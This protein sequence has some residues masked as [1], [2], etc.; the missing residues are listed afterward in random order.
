MKTTLAARRVKSR[1]FF[2][3]AAIILVT[4]LAQCALRGFGSAEVRQMVLV[5][6]SWV[7]SFVL[8]GV[9]V[10]SGHMTPGTPGPMSGLACLVS[11]TQLTLLTGGVESPYLVTLVSV[12]L[13][14]SMFTPDLWLPTLVSLVAMLGALLVINL[15]E[16]LPPRTFLPQML[17]YGGIG[18]IGFYAGRSY[19]KLRR[20]E[21]LAQEER[22]QALE[23]LAESERLRRH[24]ENERADMERLMMVG[25]L[26]AGV[27]HE[28][29]N[30]LAFVKSNLHYLQRALTSTDR[31][32]DVAELH[33][34]LDETHQGV[35]RIQRI[36][37]DL[38]QYSHPMGTP[39]Q[40]GSPRAAMEEARRL[41]LSRLHSHSEVVLDVPEVLPNVRLGQ[42]YLMQVLLN[43]L[44]HAARALEETDP[45]RPA[46]ILLKAWRT[47]HDVQVV[48]EDNG[49]GI[50]QDMLPRLFDPFFTPPCSTKGAGLGLALC[51]E[52]VLRV[53]GT[54]T[55]E[56]RPE[57]GAR[58]ILTLNQSSASCSPSRET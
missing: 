54:L 20:A 43:L 36:I 45:E 28:V 48:V 26:A 50:P 55:A 21:Q 49:P 2:V 37:T 38:R 30:P 35:L 33:E 41:A 4:S 13:L 7:A 31:P 24:A 34:L 57:G 1:V 17:A 23:R 16:G 42:R 11:L 25:Q 53:G 3:S 52:Y 56:N 8:L 44:L 10:R 15:L 14:V 5:H 46:R 27:A 58:F 6:L 51:R 40:E 32:A 18:G 47:A 12:P 9:G 39:E 22:L 29:N 19:R